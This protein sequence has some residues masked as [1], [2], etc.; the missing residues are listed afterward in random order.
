MRRCIASWSSPLRARDDDRAL[1]CEADA[2]PEGHVKSIR[3]LG[4]L[5]VPVP[6]E[7]ERDPC[8]RILVLLADFR[9]RRFLQL[10]RREQERP[11]REDESELALLAVRG[12]RPGP[13][14]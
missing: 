4:Q 13:E 2:A 12:T 10:H 1:F 14:R 9:R 8:F 3:H 6:Y 5:V 7:P 11:R